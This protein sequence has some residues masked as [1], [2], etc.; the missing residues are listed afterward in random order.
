MRYSLVLGFLNALRHHVSSKRS[1]FG[2]PD[3]Q[4]STHRHL[5]LPIALRRIHAHKGVRHGTSVSRIHLAIRVGLRV[6]ARRAL[7]FAH[8]W[9]PVHPE[10]VESTEML[11]HVDVR[12]VPFVC[13]SM[14]QHHLARAQSV[15]PLIKSFRLLYHAHLGFRKDS[16][17]LNVHVR[18]GCI[19]AGPVAFDERSKLLIH[20]LAH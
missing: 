19:D 20:V 17:E 8:F 5:S 4:N 18:H 6:E 9:I 2:E 15:S 3:G 7:R 10:S 16:C 13:R 14:R 12:S 11:G 1:V